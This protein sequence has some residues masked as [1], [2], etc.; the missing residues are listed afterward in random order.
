MKVAL[1]GEVVHDVAIDASQS[2]VV[3]QFTLDGFERG[4]S[5][6]LSVEEV[7]DAGSAY[8]IVFRQYV[9]DSEQRTAAEENAEELLS[10]AIQYDRTRVAVDETIVA[11]TEVENRRDVVV[12]MVILDLPVPA[13]FAVVEESL[14]KLRSRGEIAKVEAT[15]RAVIVYLRAVERR[16]KLQLD[17]ELRAVMPVEVMA[18]RPTAYPYYDPDRRATGEASPLSVGKGS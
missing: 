11:Q 18:P 12:P 9:D 7:G 6:R 5:A 8:Q 2:E 10:I 15:P 17:Y 4:E 14:E 3:Q 1:D 16:A 13:G